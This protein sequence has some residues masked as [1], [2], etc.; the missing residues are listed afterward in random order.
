[1]IRW[2]RRSRLE[3]LEQR[4]VFNA[5]PVASKPLWVGGVYVEEDSGSDAHGDSFYVT[6][7][8]GVA[9]TK[10]TKLV[11]NTD[12]NTQGY[13]VADNLFDTLDGGR[14]ADHSFGFKVESLEAKDPNARVWAD[15][16]DGSMQLVLNFEN[17]YAG[18]RLVFSIDVDEVQHLYSTADIQEF[19]EGLDP[20]TSG[21]EFE[22]S[23][24]RAEF[25]APHYENAN[26][27]GRFFNRYD[28]QLDQAKQAGSELGLPADNADGKRDR[29]S[30]VAATTPQILIPSSIAGKVYLD[31]NDNGQ[32]DPTES[33][34]GG[35]T[36]ELVSSQTITGEKIRRTVT[37]QS[38]GTYRFDSIPPGLYELFE[39]QPVGL[40]D[41]QDSVGRFG[42][43]IR[44]SL[45]A[46]DRI[47]NI[48][49]NGGD[50]GI[51][52]NFGELQPS[53]I[54]GNVHIGLPGF[55]CFSTDPKG[56]KPLADV[57]ITLVDNL[58]KVVATT[59]TDATGAYR[60]NGLP[61]GLYAVIESQ[62]VGLI[63]GASKAGLVDGITNG[64]AIS[65]TRIE[66]IR[67]LGGQTAIEYDFC[68]RLPSSIAGKV[69]ED[70]D[71]NGSYSPNEDPI[72]GV[73]IELIDSDGTVIASTTTISDG[74]YRFE[75]LAP[76]T[77][78]IR[79]RQPSG[80][81]Q[82]GQ[83]SGSAGGNALSTDTISSIVLPDGLDAI[84][85]DF[86]EIPP[87]VI[88]G[89][90]FQDGDELLT[91]DGQPPSDLTG[92]R[93]GIRTPDD[94]PIAGSKLIL[95]KLDGSLLSAQDVLPGHF[96]DGLIEVITDATGFYRFDG[97]R[98]GKYHI[99]QVSS[100]SNLSDGWDTPGTTGGVAINAGQ[101]IPSDIQDAIDMLANEQGAD[102]G[103]DALLFVQAIARG[104]SLENNF[105]E[106]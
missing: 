98:P 73:L 83:R 3:K 18:D 45:I 103:R 62:P 10:L 9:N 96:I 35:V 1:M 72:R 70:L 77:Y 94:R 51:E 12:Q 90:V 4:V 68:E 69:Y 74:S 85:Y 30:G 105:S 19:N 46:N 67:L 97:L 2:L 66:S 5:D 8:G 34:L 75:G 49:L 42:N 27:S 13:S 44:G 93:E 65:G 89:Y 92:I 21:A 7:E 40:F 32:Q 33:G 102:P 37:T 23:M 38:D 86:M 39:A 11:I 50:V 48:L 47:G 58:G 41:G 17:F 95:R 99:Y 63:D 64:Q 55:A 22:G 59:Q 29:S 20:I 76:R 78:T 25:S 43:E 61:K 53:T 100:A 91:S 6:F 106:I 84:G 60:F 80:Y 87:G 104:V 15:V 24:F 31:N 57:T 82:G 54:S 52:Y 88:S 28:S 26:A 79:Q 71:E 36:I 81:F 56:S 14:G 101:S 16:L